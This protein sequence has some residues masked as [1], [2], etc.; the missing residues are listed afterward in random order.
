MPKMLVLI[1][2]LQVKFLA[3]NIYRMY[4]AKLSSALKVSWG[5]VFWSQVRNTQKSCIQR[6]LWNWGHLGATT[7]ANINHLPNLIFYLSIS[8]APLKFNLPP[9]K[10][11]KKKKKRVKMLSKNQ[12]IPTSDL[13]QSDTPWFLSYR[14]ICEHSQWKGW[15]NVQ[16]SVR[17]ELCWESR[18]WLYCCCSLSPRNIRP[19][20]TWTSQNTPSPKT[21]TRR[22]QY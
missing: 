15:E 1:E 10:L 6:V 9:T 11:L 17:G 19:Y 22:L 21:D 16:T 13:A 18:V 8:Y 12:D 2:R 4:S 7:S 5:E 3:V 14:K 20:E